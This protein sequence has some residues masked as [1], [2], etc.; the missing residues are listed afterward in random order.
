MQRH[1]LT[2]FIVQTSKTVEVVFTWLFRSICVHPVNRNSV[3][4][5]VAPS[6]GDV[7]TFSRH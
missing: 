5:K 6:L 3:D 7:M 4:L 1:V 2:L